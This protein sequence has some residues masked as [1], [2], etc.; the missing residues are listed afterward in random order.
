VF[1]GV[2]DQQRWSAVDVFGQ[3]L[4]GPIRFARE[5][6]LPELPVFPGQVALVIVGEHP[7]PPAVE[8]GAVPQRVGHRLESAIA[9]AGQQGLV[10][11]AV[12]NG[13]VLAD[14]SVVPGNGRPVEAVM[15]GQDSG[16]PLQIAALDRQAQGE[17][18]DL[19]AA[20]GQLG[21]VLDRQFAHPEAAL[22]CRDQQALFGQAGERLPDDG[23]AYPEPFGES[24]HL[25]LLAGMQDAV[26]QLRPENLV[27]L[28]GASCGS[29]HHTY[30]IAHFP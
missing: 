8:L 3:H 1:T 30:T 11:V 22:R 23:L 21:D 27:H 9:A 25:Q 19:D 15:R 29:G 17:R 12:L 10:K 4:D 16:L 14:R 7:V 26:E 5:R 6:E 24:D 28:F 18:F 2:R 20:L 13:P